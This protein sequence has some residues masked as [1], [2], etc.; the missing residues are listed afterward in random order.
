M[1]EISQLL[2]AHSEQWLTHN[3]QNEDFDSKQ[4]DRGFDVHCLTGLT[5]H[6]FQG[7]T[8]TRT[9]IRGPFPKIGLHESIDSPYSNMVKTNTSLKKYYRRLPH[10][11]KRIV[12]SISE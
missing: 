12:Y 2:R 5:M 8:Y 9:I 1:A 3:P 7:F 11:R 4:L 10:Y 6:G